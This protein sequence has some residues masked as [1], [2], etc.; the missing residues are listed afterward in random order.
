MTNLS[1]FPTSLD[2]NV[3][4]YHVSDGLRVVL[5]ED[6]NPGDTSI[7]VLGD[8]EMM[9]RFTPTGIITLTEQC[10]E[11]ELRAISFSYTSRTLTTFDGLTVL[12]GFTDVGKPKSITHVTQNVMAQHHNSLKDALKNIEEFAGK[13]GA[14]GVRPLEG[15]LEERIN[16][17]RSIVLQPKAWFTSNK[18]IGLYPLTVEFTNKSFRLGTD[19]NSQSVSYI[20]DFEYN[21]SVITPTTICNATSIVPSTISHVLINDLD[22]GTISKTYYDPGIYSV[23][24]TVTNDFGS[25]SVIFDDY[26]QAR[27]PAPLDACI[28]FTQRAFQ[29]VTAGTNPT[30]GPYDQPSS[31]TPVIRSPVNTIIDMYIPPGENLT[32]RPGYSFAGEKLNGSSPIDPIIQ[33]TWS[34]SDDIPHSNAPTARAV[35]SVGGYY[36]L[37][38]RC[39]TQFGSYKITKYPKAFDIVE[40]FN[41]WLWLAT[42][43]LDESNISVSEFGLLSETFKTA[44]ANYT[45]S[46]NFDFLEDQGPPTNVVIPNKAQ[47]QRE[48]RGNVGFA[49]NTTTTSGNGGSGYLYWATGRDYN[50]NKSSEKVDAASFNGLQQSYDTGFKTDPLSP[51]TGF[52][53]VWNW[54]DLHSSNK[55]W[56]ILGGVDTADNLIPAGTSPTNQVKSIVSLGIGIVNSSTS[57]VQTNYKNNADELLQNAA[58]DQAGNLVLGHMSVYRST[59]FEDAGYFLRNEGVG[60]FFRIKSFYKTSGTSA[61]YVQDIRKLPDMSGVSRVEGKFVSLSLGVYFFSNAGAVS[62]YSPS[63]GVWGT[64]GPGIN[65]PAFRVLQDTEVVGYDDG[66]QTLLCASDGDKIAYLSF[67]YSNKTFIK[68]NETDTTFTSVT[69][70]PVGTQFHMAIF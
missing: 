22:G 3:T 55:L 40:K 25:D 20:W 63:A 62:A 67:D 21:P 51:V 64:G 31:T 45:I 69:A 5:A 19:G 30:G 4:L 35:Y 66:D 13:K 24:L 15:T 70:R 42:D 39:D 47:Q 26:I 52:P 54:V 32:N 18:Q 59:W 60:T 44:T 1:N 8:E 43:P 10:S 16:Y 53:R 11:P 58:F 34:L 61:D 28:E 37:I 57:F 65:S 56:F 17:L 46:R 68:F 50:Q 27:F 33:Y 36:D 48:F 41:L 2:T 9:R 49:R 29:S 7:T 6:Y 12:E 23:K 14:V 38:L